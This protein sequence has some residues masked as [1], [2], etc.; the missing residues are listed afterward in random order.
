MK[1]VFFDVDTQLD[2]LFPAGALAVPGAGDIV[3]ALDQL[4]RFAASHQIPLLSTADAHS[5]DDPEFKVWK[6][7]CVSGTAG[8]QKVAV[9]LL[10]QRIVLGSTPREAPQIIIEKQHIDCFTNP[11]LHPLLQSLGAVRYIVYGVASE[12]CVRYA[13]SGLLETGACVELVT[14]A[15]KSLSLA[16]EQEMIDRF[17]SA[18]GQLTTV[19]AVT[20]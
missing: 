18:G 19:A 16:A 15:I 6:P 2:F 12:V 8:Q 9:T 14:D 11:N 3:P 1:T 7:H 4:T 13:L 20:S 17:R 10:N 5:E